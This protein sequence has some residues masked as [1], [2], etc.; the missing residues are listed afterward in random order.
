MFHV[1]ACVILATIAIP[2]VAFLFAT[3][4]EMGS[5]FSLIGTTRWYIRGEKEFGLDGFVKN[6]A[7]FLPGDLDTDLR[8][9]NVIVTGGNAGL[10]FETARMLASKNASVHVLCRSKEKGEE[11]LREMQKS[12][13]PHGELHLHIVDVSSRAQVQRFSKEWLDSGKPINSLILN[14]GVLPQ[15]RSVTSEGHETGWAT[16]MMQSYLM[17]GLLMPALAKAEPAPGRAIHV[18]SGGQYTA[19]YDAADPQCERKKGFD[20]RLQYSITKRAQVMLAEMWAGKID[21]AA[22]SLKGK[23][24]SNSMHPGWALTPG[25]QTSISDFAE[26]HKGKLRSLEQGADTVVWLAATSNPAATAA[27]GE[28]FFDRKPVEKDFCLS[29]TRSSDRDF[30]KLWADCEL[31]TGHKWDAEKG[32]LVEVSPAATADAATAGAGAAAAEAK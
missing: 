5:G 19:S 14:A 1:K 12:K 23:V 7:S 17:T 28:F 29:G 13:G 27:N 11:A 10:G 6:A 4:F 25:V 18:S 22:S 3:F 31:W 15:T 26:S 2:F 21:A 16:M 20:G 9:R 8:G 30:Q 24:V 32:R